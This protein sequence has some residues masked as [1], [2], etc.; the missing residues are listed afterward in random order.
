MSNPTAW[1][2]GLGNVLMGDDGFGPAVVQAFQAEFEVDDEV[3]VV[4][5][6]TPGLDLTPWLIDASLAIVVDAI[7]T[8]LPPGGLR[9]YDK[10]DL[11]RHSPNPR[12]GP[13]DPGL[14]ESLHTL[15]FAGRAPSSVRLI[16]AVPA[17]TEMSLRLSPPLQ[18]AVPAAAQM[19]ADVLR[20]AGHVVTPRAQ[21]LQPRPWWEA[22]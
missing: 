17:V 14:S 4:D 21:S 7:K 11:L 16:G 20:A 5:L 8:D 9:S 3:A 6:G 18:A 2:L 10:A 22:R 1:V 19:V 15:E 13:H 12:V